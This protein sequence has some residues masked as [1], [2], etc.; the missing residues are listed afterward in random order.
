VTFSAPFNWCDARCERCPL[1]PECPLRRRQLQHA[2]VHEAKGEDP[3]D[4]SSVMADV[5]QDLGSA[6]RQL[7]D[8]VAEEGI[9]LDAPM[10]KV[11]IVLDAERLHRAGRALVFGLAK[12]GQDMSNVTLFMMKCARLSLSVADDDAETF[13]LD[14]APNL[15]LIERLRSE[16]APRIEAASDETR[17]AAATIDRVL[18]PLFAKLDDASRR[19]MAELVAKNA[20]PSPFCVSAPAL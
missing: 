9:D 7:E 8:F 2:W 5:A 18:Q 16:L 13:A 12:D 4:P 20:A 10:P 3:D 15:L 6:L 1:E 19:E 11:P 17:A 14:A